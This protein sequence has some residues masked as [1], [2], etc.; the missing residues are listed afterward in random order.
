[1]EPRPFLSIIIPCFNEET[2][3]LAS[4][5]AFYQYLKSRKWQSEVILVNDGSSDNT[6]VVLEKLAKDYHFV[7][8]LSYEKNQGKGYAIQFGMVEANG[9]IIG[10]M[11]ADFATALEAIPFAIK[12]IEKGA[13]IVLGN[14]NDPHSKI[15]GDS[16]MRHYLSKILIKLNQ[17]LFNLGKI[18]DTQC[19]FKF[20]KKAVAKDLFSRMT[21]F[22]WLFDLD[23]LAMAS[24]KK[25]KIVSIPIV[26]DNAQD[27]KVK[28]LKDL[29]PVS[30]DLLR[31]FLKVKL[32][33]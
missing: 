29:F 21:I 33:I 8:A 28:L 22:R 20:F 14:R 18:D 1:M 30:K 6:K 10:F 15:S 3:I 12:E 24:A 13:D 17:L 31:I 16:L 9:E 32:S 23:I 26:W 2:R 7:R 4:F 5:D 19:G 11:D 27:S 25:Y